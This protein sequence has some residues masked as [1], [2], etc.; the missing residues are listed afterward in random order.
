MDMSQERERRFSLADRVITVGFW[1]NAIL[2]I[3]KLAAGY[4]G[5][6]EAVFADG[7]ESACDFVAIIFTLIALRIGRKAFDEDHPYGHGKAECLAAILVSLIIFTAGI[8]IL[9]KAVMTFVTGHYPQPQLI[10][11]AAAAAT[12]AIKEGLFRYT[13]KVARKLESPAVDAVAKDHRK[14]ALTS[15]ATLIGVTGAYFGIVYL[16]PLAAGLTS[17][18]IFYIGWETLK[19]AGHDLMDGRPPR[20]ILTQICDSACEVPG[21]DRVHEIRG[22]RSGQYLIIDLKLEMDPDMTVRRSH[23]IAD[24]VKSLI[25]SRFSNVGDVMIHI[26]PGNE[27]H[28]DLI[29]L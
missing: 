8:G 5:N 15:V 27:A 3:M 6:S 26:N 17:F 16:D 10:A 7:I 23:E 1:L 24:Q 22:R 11:V 28:K 2:M 19:K 25:F 21:V 12:I 20:D 29:R 13:R 14:D 4:Y 9:Y 18:F